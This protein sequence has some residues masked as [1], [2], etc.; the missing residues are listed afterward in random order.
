MPFFFP[1]VESP[2]VVVSNGLLKKITEGGTPSYPN[3]RI[4]PLLACRLSLDERRSYRVSAWLNAKWGSMNALFSFS[5][6]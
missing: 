1:Y 5:K 4:L 6:Q 3:A 2:G